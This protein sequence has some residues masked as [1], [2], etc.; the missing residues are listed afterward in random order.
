VSMHKFI[1]VGSAFDH[2][3]R[4]LPE[5]VQNGEW[6]SGGST[7]LGPLFINKYTS[8]AVTFTHYNEAEREKMAEEHLVSNEKLEKEMT[9]E[10]RQANRNGFIMV[11]GSIAAL[12]VYAVLMVRHYLY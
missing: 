6:I 8:E 10:Q 7:F 4:A 11:C 3:Y 2:D 1:E 5:W 9:E 12:I